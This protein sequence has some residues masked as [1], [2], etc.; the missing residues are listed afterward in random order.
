MIGRQSNRHPIRSY[1]NSCQLY[2][3]LT[4]IFFLLRRTPK[5][6][7]QGAEDLKYVKSYINIVKEE[8][9][10]SHPF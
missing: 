9:F 1:Q 10:I 8:A 7:I 3:M 4:W 5:L 2:G 6:H